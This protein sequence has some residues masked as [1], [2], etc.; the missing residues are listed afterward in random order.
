MLLLRLIELSKTKYNCTPSTW[1]LQ[2]WSI[3][4]GQFLRLQIFLRPDV[5]SPRFRLRFPLSLID[6]DE[7]P[8]S[9]QR[10]PE[11]VFL[12][13]WRDSSRVRDVLQQDERLELQAQESGGPK[14]D[15]S[16][17]YLLSWITSF[18]K[19]ELQYFEFVSFGNQSAWSEPAWSICPSRSK[20]V[21]I[22]RK[23]SLRLTSIQN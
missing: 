3:R 6:V 19:V 22:P 20:I 4:L 7:Y 16:L 18:I 5:R 1:C 2:M 21:E 14:F 23:G 17:A 15:S 10:F 13:G 11:E 8:T 9:N 12:W